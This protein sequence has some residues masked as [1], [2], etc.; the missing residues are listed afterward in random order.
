[1]RGAEASISRSRATASETQY[2]RDVVQRQNP[3]SIGA[4]DPAHHVERQTTWKARL[5]RH[6]PEQHGAVKKPR[7]VVRESREGDVEGH[8]AERP[9]EVNADQTDD[10]RFEHLCHPADQHE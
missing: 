9:R 1:V 8:N 10:R 6:C 4:A 5:A 3:R 2:R 7:C